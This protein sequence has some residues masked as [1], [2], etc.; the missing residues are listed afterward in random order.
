MARKLS[1]RE[2]IQRVAYGGAVLGAAALVTRLRFDPG[3]SA[4]ARASGER[5]VRDYRVEP[6]RATPRMA[7]ARSSTD[8][9]TLTR[10]AIDGIGG[11]RSFVSR[12]DVVAIKP[13]IGW[14][15]LP[16]HAANT[17]PE[18]V[19]EVVRLA[20]DAGARRVVVADV[21]CNE[22]QRSFQRSGIW[23]AAHAAGATVIL[24]A[25][26][27]FR[28]IRL[29]GDVLDRWPIFTPIT[30]ADKVINLPI[31]KHHGLTKLSAAMKNWYGL[32]GGRRNQLHQRIDASIVDLARFMRPT[33]TVLDATRVL[34]RNGPQGGN[35]DDTREMH[36]VVAGLDEVAL[37]AYAAVLIGQRPE[38]IGYLR[39]GQELGLGTLD[40]ESLARVEV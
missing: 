38:E 34:V 22:A 12:G 7:I 23:N 30:D 17:H 24:P 25:E 13:N 35:L 8:P 3:G 4:V 6:D 26:H 32:L 5:Q 1:R 18:V 33:L 15:R 20:F 16:M 27:R 11:M 28:E 37:D 14:D 21:S 10:L 29:R 36:Q 39:L 31:A 9:A 19:A 2:A 40:W